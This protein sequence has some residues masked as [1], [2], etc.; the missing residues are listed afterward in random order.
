MLAL[1]FLLLCSAAQADLFR[2]VDPETGSVKISNTPPPWYERSGGPAVERVPY[3]GPGAPSSAPV[4]GQRSVAQLQARWRELLL[5]VSSQPTPEN[6]RA[7][8]QVGAE[9]DR[10][11]PAGA[12]RRKEEISVALRATRR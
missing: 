5:T 11:D 1:A 9:L 2:W 7:F 3:Q 6:L 8:A 12:A 10:A 4:E